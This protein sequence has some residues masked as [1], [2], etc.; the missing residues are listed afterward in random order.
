MSQVSTF[1][2]IEPAAPAPAGWR[3]CAFGALEAAAFTVPLSLGSATLV[4][5]QFGP[6][7]LS[8]GV[9]ATLLALAFLHIAAVRS[10]RPLLYAARFFEATTLAAMLGQL[11]PHLAD[12]S[13]PDTTGV[14]LAL[15]A[16]LV[17]GAGIW[18]GVLYMVRADRFSRYIPAPVFAGFATSI[19]VV[20]VISQVQAAAGLLASEPARVVLSVA[21]VSLVTGFAVRRWRPRW[22]AATTALAVGLLAG[23]AWKAGGYAVAMLG[24]AAPDARLPWMAADFGAFLAPGVPVGAVAGVVA[25]H[26]AVLGTMMFVN[27]TLTAQLLSHADGKPREGRLSQAWLAGWHALAGL[28]GSAPLSGSVQSSSV[29]ARDTPI[30]PATM[31]ATAVIMG[32]IALSGLVTWTPLAAVVGTLLAEAWFIVDRTSTGNLR[33]WL[34][35]QE[36]QGHAREDLAL[37]AAVTF[38]AVIVNMIAAV[39]AGLG[40]GLLLFAARNAR[41]PVRRVLSGAQVSSNCARSRAD[42]RTLA[43]FGERLRVLELERDLFFGAVDSLERTLTE[44]LNRCECVVLDWTQVRHLDSSAA[45]AIAK[46]QQAAALVEAPVFHVEPLHGTE[47]ATVLAHYVNRRQGG[48]DL[49]RTLE[50]AENHLLVLHREA[51]GTEATSMVEA[52]SLLHGLSDAQRTRVEGA[53]LQQLVSRGQALVTAGDASSALLL[54][55]QGS[56]S[57]VLPQADGHALRIAGVRQGATVGEMGFLDGSPRSAT[58]VAD[59]ETLV[60]VLTRDAFER[61]GREDPQAAQQVVVNIA[62]DVATRLRHANRLATARQGRQ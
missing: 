6:E 21:G 56:A 29:G 19:A 5:S 1:T 22:P 2:P 49:D 7:V 31:V 36:L 55:L 60:A 47:V 25:G 62:L 11:V 54:V 4:L 52:A 33:R 32:A 30:G 35:G 58:V 9:L 38:T 44:E 41:R 42:V 27:T 12:W 46:F 17:T 48:A 51:R 16:A 57:V 59:E 50:L 61:L 20:L 13:L 23:L 26:A 8:A 37:V 18:M 40:L 3:T 28:A 45:Q 14:R 15:L 34:A 39:F 53:M 43:A 10:R 24:T